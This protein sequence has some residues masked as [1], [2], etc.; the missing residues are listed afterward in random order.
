MGR[1]NYDW[2]NVELN[3][4]IILKPVNSKKASSKDKHEIMCH[5]GNI[6]TG[7]P[8]NLGRKTKSCGCISRKRALDK[9][10]DYTGKIYNNCTI[11]EPYILDKRTCMDKWIVKC[12]C[13]NLFETKPNDLQQNHTR[14]CGC[15]HSNL[16][17]ERASKIRKEKGL[18]KN[19]SI[20]DIQLYLK[21]NILRY[22]R[23]IVFQIDNFTCNLCNKKGYE[24]HV[25]HIYPTNSNSDYL[26][27]DKYFDF[28]DLNNL[29][30]L[31][32]KCHIAK[33]H[34]GH[35]LYVNEEIQKQ[36]IEKIYTR[37]VNQDMLKL[38]HFK[39]ENYIKPKIKEMI[40]SLK[41]D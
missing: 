23:N 35:G 37:N 39:I 38:Y 9:L 26:E 7:T 36:L 11:I 8:N 19:N 30:T 20:K 27:E 12:H 6:F 41:E 15:I 3:N 32:K 2:S 17:K 22:I 10:I 5:C 34:N 4:C 13:G 18:V 14:S 33:A 40:I 31:C 29:I 21:N 24:L 1:T 28:Y 16:M 25:H